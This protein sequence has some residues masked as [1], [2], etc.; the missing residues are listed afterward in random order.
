MAACKED[1][2]EAI[3]NMTVMEVV[4]LSRRW[5]RSSASRPRPRWPWL[6]PGG[7]ARRPLRSEEQT[8]FT[9]R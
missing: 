2:L 1:I 9:V 4:E 7:A 3:S 5:K 6:Q 8:E